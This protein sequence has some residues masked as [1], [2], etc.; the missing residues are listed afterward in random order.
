MR[1]IIFAQELDD[2][3]GLILWDGMENKGN[4]NVS[5]K[6]KI[7][8]STEYVTQGRSSLRINGG[9]SAPDS[10]VKVK[11]QNTYFDLSFAKKIVFDIYNSGPACQVAVGLYAGQRYESIPKELASGLNRNVTFELNA[12]DFK[13]ILTSE[14]VAQ[15]VEFIIYSKDGKI[16]PL[17]IDNIRVKKL[18]GLQSLPPGISPAAGALIAEGFTPVETAPVYTGS[19]SVG[20]FPREETIPISEP[21]TLFL[22]GTGIAGFL[23]NKRKDTKR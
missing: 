18:V 1:G 15:A 10:G 14:N 11:K 17:Y 20:A 7:S 9:E 6:S 19:Y 5:D 12:K 22:F 16:G 3:S 4:W 23:S 8:V 21:L 2:Q 13:F